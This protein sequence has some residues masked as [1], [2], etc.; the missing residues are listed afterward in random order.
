MGLFVP[1]TLLIPSERESLL[2][3]Y[4]SGSSVKNSAA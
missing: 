4:T 3:V 2:S 1:M